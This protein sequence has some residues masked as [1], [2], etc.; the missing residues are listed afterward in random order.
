MESRTTIHGPSRFVRRSGRSLV[1]RLEGP[2]V[3]AA[4]W[5]AVG[6]PLVYL[7]LLVTGI[8]NH[9][10]LGL[11]LGLLGV[12][13]IALIGGRNYEPGSADSNPL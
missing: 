10:E 1:D 8:D 13:G 12:H 5:L 3:A 6:L 2:M 4:Y 9:T 11:F 7:V